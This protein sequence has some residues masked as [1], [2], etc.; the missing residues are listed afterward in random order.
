M[1]GCYKGRPTL[2]CC[3]MQF[4]LAEEWIMYCNNKEAKKVIWLLTVG[5]AISTMR[6]LQSECMSVHNFCMLP[7]CHKLYLKTERG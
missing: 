2:M 1:I 6:F 5:I 4:E 3:N 7:R